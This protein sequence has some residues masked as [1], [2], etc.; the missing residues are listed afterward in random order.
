[1][2]ASVLN[3]FCSSV[4]WEKFPPELISLEC[5]LLKRSESL[6][7]ASSACVGLKEEMRDGW[8]LG[9]MPRHNQV[10]GQQNRG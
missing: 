7:S 5:V 2:S 8:P 1:M 10:D 6:S 3:E 4:R 9:E